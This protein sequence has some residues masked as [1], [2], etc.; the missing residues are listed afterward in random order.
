MYRVDTIVALIS[1]VIILCV[2][3]DDY[4]QREYQARASCN[5]HDG[6]HSRCTFFT[7]LRVHLK[8]PLTFVELPSE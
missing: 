7:I 6:D 3:F 8:A 5:S 1:Y 4:R 2:D